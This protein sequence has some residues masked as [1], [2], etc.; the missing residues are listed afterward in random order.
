M[1]LVS[2][3]AAASGFMRMDAE[4]R[5]GYYDTLEVTIYDLEEN[6]L[7]EIKVKNGE[8]I[9]VKDSDAFAEYCADAIAK[10]ILGL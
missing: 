5:W 7:A 4:C 3:M 10:V 8:D 6:R 9:F 1:T 2:D